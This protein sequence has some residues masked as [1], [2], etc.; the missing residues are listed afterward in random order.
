MLFSYKSLLVLD[1]NSVFIDAKKFPTFK[2]I[3]FVVELGAMAPKPSIT[4]ATEC[5]TSRIFRQGNKRR[6]VDH[7]IEKLNYEKM[8]F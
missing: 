5:T 2:K 4:F 3:F 1:Y 7:F 6:G 8:Y